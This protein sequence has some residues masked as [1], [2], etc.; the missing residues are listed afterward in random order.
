MKFKFL[1][2]NKFEINLLID[3][4]SMQF[5]LSSMYPY[6]KLDII[7]YDDI[8]DTAFGVLEIKFK[9]KDMNSLAQTTAET[10]IRKYLK[11][12]IQLFTKYD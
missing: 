1:K 11:T 3:E 8:E 5:Q 2:W 12:K 6:D 7:V 10:I 4:L 9:E